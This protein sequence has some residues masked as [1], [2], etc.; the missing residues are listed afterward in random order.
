MVKSSGETKMHI[1]THTWYLPWYL[2][3]YSTITVS[4]KPTWQCGTARKTLAETARGQESVRISEEM[5]EHTAPVL[6]TSRVCGNWD[7]GPFSS[8]KPRIFILAL[9]FSK[10]MSLKQC[11]KLKIGRRPY[12]EINTILRLDRS[13][14][15]ISTRRL[16]T[17]GNAHQN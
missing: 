8:A 6:A 1:I 12:L 9:V 2:V 5:L 16:D 13:Q 3:V 11:Q 10:S 17:R 4:R 7:G 15:S 14:L